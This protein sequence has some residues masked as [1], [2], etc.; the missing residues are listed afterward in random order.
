MAIPLCP[1]FNVCNGCACQ[2]IDYSLQLEN[3]KNALKHAIE[4]KEIEVYADKEYFYRNRM[5][6]LF[7]ENGVGFRQKEPAKRVDVEQCVIANEGINLLLKELRTFFKAPIDAFDSKKKSGTLRY[8][9]IRAPQNSTEESSISFT[10]NSESARIAEATEKIKQFAKQ[11]TA[12]NILITY[13]I[14]DEEESISSDYIMIKGK[15]MLKQ[16][17]MN[18]NFNYSI[19]GFF[20]NNTA[21]TEKMHMYVNNILK[22]HNTKDA[23]LLDLYAGVGTFG[24]INAELFKSVTIIEGFQGCID[25]A[26]INITENNIKNATA[27]CLDATHLRRIKFN[28]PLYVI[29]DPPRSGMDMKTIQQIIELRPEAIIYVSCNTQQLGKDVKKFKKYEIKSAALFDLFPQ[30]NHSEAVVE[31]VRKEA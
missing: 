12:K 31:L 27:L 7:F 11:T 1:Y 29:T 24:I 15:D 14:P 16:K 2:H 25:A 20:Q 17:I 19:Q 22:K 30:T 4:Y 28:N 3:K 10:L 8:A 26:K 9:V 23:Y 21:M 6:F 13:V 5:D 18:K